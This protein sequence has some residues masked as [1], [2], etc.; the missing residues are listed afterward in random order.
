[1]PGRSLDNDTGKDQIVLVAPWVQLMGGNPSNFSGLQAGS[2]TI[3]LVGQGAG[4]TGWLDVTDGA[5]FSGFQ[6]VT[7]EAA[8]DMTFSQA[9]T[10]TVPGFLATAGD[11]TLQAAR[12]YPTTQTLFAPTNNTASDP[13]GGIAAGG[14]VTILSSGAPPNPTV[15]SVDGSLAI[16]SEGAGI[17]Q[18]GYI[19][20]PLGSI[21]LSAPNG[22]VYLGSG[23]TTTV[24]A[25]NA[26]LLY[27]VIQMGTDVNSLGNNIWA[28]P[29][30]ANPGY[31]TQVQNVPTQSVS[32]TGNEVIVGQGATLDISGGTG[33]IFASRFLPSYSGSYNPLAGSYV[34]VPDGSVTL[35]GQAVYLSGM[36][37]LPA[38]TYS[39]LPAAWYDKANGNWNPTQWA[40]LPGAIIITD[41]NRT[42]STNKATLTADGYPIVGGYATL[43]GHEYTLRRQIEA[44]EVRPASLVL[45]EGQFS[46]QSITA[47]AAGTVTVS[48]NTTVLNGTIK[49]S[50]LPGYAGGSFALSGT[51]VIVQQTPVPLPSGFTFDT[52]VPADLI[53]TLYIA[54]PS[55][56]N[57]G[58]QTI[59]LGVDSTGT[60]TPQTQTVDIRPGVT[61]QAENI[62]LGAVDEIKIEDGTP[63]NGTQVLAIAAPGQTG[64][65]DLHY[66][67]GRGALMSGPTPPSTPRTALPSALP[68]STWIPR[69]P[70]TTCSLNLE[71]SAITFSTTEPSSASHGLFV[72]PYQWLGL[73]NYFNNITLTSTSDLV[74]DGTFVP[75]ANALS[76]VTDTL[77]IDAGRI[78]D[79]VAG[80]SAALSAQTIALQ[81]STGAVG[82]AN[83]AAAGGQI[84]LNA[85]Q[86]QVNQGNILFDGFAGVT[87]NGQNNVT[88][89]GVGSLTMNGGGSLAIITP[90]VAT[91]YLLTNSA[92]ASHSCQLHHQ[93][94]R[95][96]GDDAGQRCHAPRA[97]PPPA[98]PSR[99]TPARSTSPPSSKSR[100]AR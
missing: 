12:I 53:G 96:Q 61:L 20:A 43:H 4:G 98:A 49:A 8:Q 100:P 28:I 5:F 90:R 14:K 93:R 6:K 85:P 88:F 13:N 65:C 19:A 84:T 51:N 80:G 23:S 86:I 46:T 27:G 26:P 99:S 44:Y 21:S 77:T 33:S 62:L 97:L 58:F 48:G 76:A 71:G 55:L 87:M 83:P 81:N 56:S 59:G 54:A 25:G 1:M 70:S 17:D 50:S 3:S 30:K 11:L 22:R 78:M 66:R 37:G 39:L 74:F 64:S 40:Y 15:Y 38:G 2:N 29:N 89:S 82:S 79:S 31:Y 47:G 68:T 72:T 57:Q 52:A 34:I 60:I 36:A 41:L 18:E 10:S 7:L 91:S 63:G 92:G 75:G 95:G 69:R 32:L 42:L 45:S 35:P 67:S 24:A 94:G 9:S 16:I 73:T